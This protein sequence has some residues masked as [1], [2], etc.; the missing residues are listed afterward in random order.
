MFKN[1]FK[2]EQQIV[3]EIHNEFDTAEDRL[4]QEANSLLT[5]LNLQTESSMQAKAERLTSLGFVN[6]APVNWVKNNSLVK[7]KEQADLIRY[8]K[9]TYPFQ[10]FLTESELERICEKYNLIFAPVSY[11]KKDVPDK[12]ISE[13]E[14]ASSLKMDDSA[15]NIITTKLDYNG[16]LNIGNTNAKMKGLP[17]IIKGQSFNSWI[18]ADAYLRKHYSSKTNG[19]SYIVNKCTTT[20]EER[21]GL[22][23]AAPQS[24]FNLNGLKKSGKYAFLNITITEVKDPIVFRYCRGGIQVL[25]KWGLEASDELLLNEIEN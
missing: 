9:Q 25:S 6:S 7:T 15:K 13:I 24:H 1:L 16:V 5:E 3:A 10:K 2:S 12:N 11:Y 20:E 4:L 23:I 22:F 8:Y 17:F 21:Q 19:I 18:E 14:R